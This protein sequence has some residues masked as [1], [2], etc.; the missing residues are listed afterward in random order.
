VNVYCPDLIPPTHTTLRKLN[1]ETIREFISA[2]T[3]EE[4]LARLD[5][6]TDRARYGANLPGGIDVEGYAPS[7]MEKQTLK[8][9]LE[10]SVRYLPEQ[11][12]VNPVLYQTIDPERYYVIARHEGYIDFPAYGRKRYNN[13]VFLLKFVMNEGLIQEYFEYSNMLKTYEA[14]EVQIPAVEKPAGWPS[15]TEVELNFDYHQMPKLIMPENPDCITGQNDELRMKNIT[16]LRE[17][18]DAR[19]PVQRAA[20]WDLFTDMGTTGAAGGPIVMGKDKVKAC[21]DWNMI[22]FPDT[23]FNNNMI[24]QTQDPNLFMVESD[25][26]CYI[27]YPAYGRPKRYPNKFWHTF[28]MENGQIMDYYE[29]SNALLIRHTFQLAVPPLEIPSGWPK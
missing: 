13:N 4:R 29:F 27:S 26:D 21:T 6:F 12:F 24:Y 20:R 1:C 9:C 28:R 11:V 25:G 8:K 14:L 23:V 5:L 3:D 2:K 22:Y 7:L 18:V 15:V 10:W 19:Y 17:Y 16:A